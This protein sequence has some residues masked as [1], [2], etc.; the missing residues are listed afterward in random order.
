MCEVRLELILQDQYLS[1]C[2]MGGDRL[3]KDR[4]TNVTIFIESAGVIQS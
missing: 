4:W 2:Q 3:N 1:V